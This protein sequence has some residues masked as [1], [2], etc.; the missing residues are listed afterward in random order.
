M[1]CIVGITDGKRIVMGCDSAG[2]SPENPEIYNVAVDKI[3]TT[4][5]YLVGICGSYR[6]G[7]IGAGE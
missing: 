2:S 1:T 5:E 4:G 7:Q 6:A 3:F